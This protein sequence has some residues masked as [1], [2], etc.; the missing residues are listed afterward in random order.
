[1]T[2]NQVCPTCHRAF[3]PGEHPVVVVEL[4]REQTF[5]GE[6]TEVA[7]GPATAYHPDCVPEDASR[8]KVLGQPPP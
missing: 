4:I 5:G 8:Y 3:A 1:M 2:D 7:E 6:P